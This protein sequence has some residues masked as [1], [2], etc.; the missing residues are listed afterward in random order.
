MGGRALPE[1]WGPSWE[2]EARVW[3][4]DGGGDPAFLGGGGWWCLSFAWDLHSG[5]CSS[6]KVHEVI[7]DGEWLLPLPPAVLPLCTAHAAWGGGGDIQCEPPPAP[8]DPLDGWLGE[9]QGVQEPAP[10]GQGVTWWQC[11]PLKPRA[12]RAPPKVLGG[13]AAGGKQSGVSGTPTLLACWV[14]GGYAPQKWATWGTDTYHRIP[15][16][17]RLHLK[18]ER[19]PQHPAGT[20]IGLPCTPKAQPPRSL[21]S[22]WPRPRAPWAVR[23][24]VSRPGTEMCPV[25]VPKR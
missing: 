12:P 10:A 23:V 17:R 11:S 1:V 21:P 8:P 7:S 25:C 4:W 13:F 18:G 9:G 14:Q 20:H 5:P 16:D 6:T 3:P 19:S 24:P 2:C 22:L 15:A